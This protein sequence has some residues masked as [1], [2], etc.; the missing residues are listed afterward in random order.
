M[1][2]LICG[3]GAARASAVAKAPAVSASTRLAPRH[4]RSNAM[5][6]TTDR[7]YLSGALGIGTTFEETT[8]VQSRLSVSWADV[9]S[10]IRHTKADTL[11]LL[12]GRS[13]AVDQGP[14]LS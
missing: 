3:S 6:G 13:A 10:A 1:G 12:D 14:G 5:N 9:G 11:N 4:E 2:G 8:D 7:W